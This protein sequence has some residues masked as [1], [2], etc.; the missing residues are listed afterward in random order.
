[1]HDSS[2]FFSWISNNLDVTNIVSNSDK[3]TYAELAETHP[4]HL[5]QQLRDIEY[6]FPGFFSLTERDLI[7]KQKEAALLEVET[8]ERNDRMI[9]MKEYERTMI[10]ALTKMEEEKIES[11]LELKFLTEEVE[12]KMVKLE[13]LRKGN[14]KKIDASNKHLLVSLKAV[15]KFY[16]ILLFFL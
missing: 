4:E 12:R 14:A 16:L 2:L 10:K 5:E 3:L 13:T 6:E 7:E 15:Y 1:M 9:R 11:D 8:I